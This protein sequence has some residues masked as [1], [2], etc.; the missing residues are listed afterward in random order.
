MKRRH[1]ATLNLRG[2]ISAFLPCKLNDID[3]ALAG[4][5]ERTSS[6]SSNAA[7]KGAVSSGEGSDTKRQEEKSIP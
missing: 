7:G 1:D 4:L 5:D 6:P 2:V 3:V